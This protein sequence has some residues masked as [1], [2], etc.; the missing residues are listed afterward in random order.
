MPFAWLRRKPGWSPPLACSAL[1]IRLGVR[2]EGLSQPPTYAN[3]AATAMTTRPISAQRPARLAGGGRFLGSCM[4]LLLPRG[5]AFQVW[6]IRPRLLFPSGGIIS[7]ERRL[8]VM[9]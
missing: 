7:P 2:R 6:D 1:M 8:T 9:E 4:V 3:A 5:I